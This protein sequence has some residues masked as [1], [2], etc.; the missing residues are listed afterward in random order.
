MTTVAWDG[1]ILAADSK[2]S[3]NK[4]TRDHCGNCNE[5]I[6]KTY[7]DTTKIQ[8]PKHA[9]ILFKGQELVAWAGCGH[10]PI[11]EMYGAGLREGVDILTIGRMA[12]KVYQDRHIKPSL[13]L[14]VVT[15]ETAYEVSWAH[16]GGSIVQ[17]I[18]T[19]PY[20]IGSGSKAAMLAM[21][22]LGYTAPTAV[23]C[24]IDV[25]PHSGGDV[26]YVDCRG[27][28]EER[29]MLRYLYTPADIDEL[30]Q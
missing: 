18:T 13:T 5:R 17:E 19:I 22:R 24:G 15:T 29:E 12:C 3:I 21:K 26:C 30:F 27:K 28:V 10:S 8:L 7:R 16:G 4:P 23:A 9:G 2:E 25:D 6:Q 14:I 11:I 20:S 1:L